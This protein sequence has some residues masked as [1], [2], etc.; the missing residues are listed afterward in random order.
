MNYEHSLYFV[1]FSE[2]ILGIFQNGPTP[3][4]NL[5]SGPELPHPISKVGQKVLLDQFRMQSSL[6]TFNQLTLH[7]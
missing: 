7:S 6:M 2:L 5:K 3:P 4:P 1:V